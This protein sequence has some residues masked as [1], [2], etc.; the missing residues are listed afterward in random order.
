M[1]GPDLEALNIEPDWK[2]DRLH[3]RQ[4]KRLMTVLLDR[5]SHETSGEKNGSKFGGP[6]G[7]AADIR[8]KTRQDRGEERDKS[9]FH[10]NVDCY[11][12]NTPR[13]Q[14]LQ[15]PANAC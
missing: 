12:E 9:G 15:N 7:P 4:R 10:S 2:V 8:R 13:R 1:T 5:P 3:R 6:E 11:L 14:K